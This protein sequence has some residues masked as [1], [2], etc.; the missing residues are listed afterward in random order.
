LSTVYGIVKQH[1]G[2]ITVYSEPGRGTTFKVYLPEVEE[3]AEQ[4][5]SMQV[6]PQRPQGKETVLVVEDEEIVRNLASE[7]LDM[8]GYSVLAAG[9]PDEAKTICADHAGTIDLLLTDVVLPGMDGR[10]LF[11]KLSPQRPKMKVLYVSGYTE[12]FVVHHG[13]LDPGVNFL[14]KPFTVDGLARK[15]REVLDKK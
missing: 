2:H 6:T 5:A 14:P 15:V 13:I 9:D 10:S 4:P 1:R 8:L 12:N 3:P 11:E 7:A